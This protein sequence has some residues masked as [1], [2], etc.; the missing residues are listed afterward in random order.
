MALYNDHV[1]FAKPVHQSNGGR[2]VDSLRDVFP[3][4]E[5]CLRIRDDSVH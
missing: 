2:T 5:A 4:N 3:A 1:R